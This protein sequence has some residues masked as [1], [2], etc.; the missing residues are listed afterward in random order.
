MIT[1]TRTTIPFVPEYCVIALKAVDASPKFLRPRLRIRFRD[2]QCLNLLTNRAVV[3]CC[4]KLFPF[5][6]PQDRGSPVACNFSSFP[7][8]EFV[9]LTTC[10]YYFGSSWWLFMAVC[11][12]VHLLATVSCAVENLHCKILLSVGCR[13]S[14]C[15]ANL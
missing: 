11:K 3:L 2:H 7:V 1:L 13:K 9:K 6:N 14:G 12:F 5:R 15:R 4:T 10:H 8:K